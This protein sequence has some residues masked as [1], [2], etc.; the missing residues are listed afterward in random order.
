MLF[1]QGL[2]AAAAL[3]YEQ[4]V[5][6]YD[7]VLN[8]QADCYEVWYERGLALEGRGDYIE[9][10]SS[11]DRALSLR[12]KDSSACEIWHER[13]NAFHYGLGDYTQALSC[14]D[15]ALKLV[16]DHE[17]VWHN[18]GSLLFY[19][20]SLPEEAIACYDRTL[21]INPDY[22][23]CWRNRGNALAELRCYDAAIASYDRALA[24]KPGDPVCWEARNLAVGK[25]GRPYH[26]PTTSPIFTMGY[27]DQTFVEGDTDSNV[28]FASAHG[29]N[30]ETPRTLSRHPLLVIEDDWGRREIL[31]ERD[32]YSVGR[33]L[34]SDI[35]L[36]SRF[37]SRQHAVLERLNPDNETVAYQITDGD[38]S[39]TPST[40][41]LII[42]GRK[43]RSTELQSEDVIV[44]GPKVQ[45]VFKMVP[46][47]LKNF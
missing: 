8:Q 19:G 34:K 20:M 6:Y 36:H 9:A 15:Q 1:C 27:G 38:F 10:I 18:R 43:C 35:C 23:L 31:L 24:L 16:P 45:A 12:P 32:R 29:G 47:G 21:A 3:N 40:N 42:N 39:G 17:Q 44:F 2:A 7:Q 28:V 25:S 33:D 5:A 4:A 30:G 13:G 14:Y 41:G 26:Q 22:E 11:Y 37:V 46:A